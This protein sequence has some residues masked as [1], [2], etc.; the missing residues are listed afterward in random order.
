[1]RLLAFSLV[2]AVATGVTFTPAADD[3]PPPRGVKSKAPA[4]RGAAVESTYYSVSTIPLP[5]DCVLEVGG[6]AFRPDG[7]LLAC[8]RR[9][10]VWLI[11]NP[12]SDSLSEVKFTK[13][14][15]GLH[16][17]L[18]LSVQDNNTVFVVQRPELTRLVDQ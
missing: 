15:S 17:A 1:M 9:G 3:L 18:G 10:E 11:D 4:P 13:F 8:T 5:P 14:A 7:K 6:L 16:E 12:T 2:L